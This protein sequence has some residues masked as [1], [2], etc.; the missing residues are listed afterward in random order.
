[1]RVASY[2]I[3]IYERWAQKQGKSQE[4][5]DKVRDVFRMA[6]MLHDVGKVAISD[7]ILKKPARFTPEEFEVMKLHTV[8][9]AQLFTE[10]Q[11][12]FDEAA[13]VVALTHHERWDGQGYPGYVDLTTGRPI[14]DFATPEGKA[15]GKA[16]E[17]IPLMGRIVAIADVY[18]ALCSRRVYKPAWDEQEALDMIQQGA[19]GQFDAELVDIFFSVLDQIRS[20]RERYPDKMEQAPK[21][22]APGTPK[23]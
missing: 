14:P 4:D 17:E 23:E 15:K 20:I 9:G 13:G 7:T 2:S 5:I 18:D 3:E 19:G 22:A 10:K 6:A 1:N 16:G 11:S 21:Q 8:M 12:D